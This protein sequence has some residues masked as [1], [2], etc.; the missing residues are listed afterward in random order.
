MDDK[1]NPEQCRYNY[2]DDKENQEQCRHNHKD[3]TE[4]PIYLVYIV[5]NSK[6]FYLYP[7]SCIGIVPDFL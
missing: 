1:E 6:R 2:K 7:C 5:N 3:D 4:N